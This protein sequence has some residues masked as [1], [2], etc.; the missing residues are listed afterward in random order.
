MRERRT[1]MEALMAAAAAA[2][3]FLAS[4]GLA[5]M[6]AAL[7]LRGAFWMMGGSVRQMKFASAA[8]AQ[9]VIAESARA[10]LVPVRAHRTARAH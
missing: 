8:S 2:E 7:A 6:F 3:I 5:A 10:G 9:S 4:L 1:A